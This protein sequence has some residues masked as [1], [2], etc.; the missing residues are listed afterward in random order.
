MALDPLASWLQATVFLSNIDIVR[1]AYAESYKLLPE[2]IRRGFEDI[3]EGYLGDVWRSLD[4]LLCMHVYRDLQYGP[5][6]KVELRK[7]IKLGWIA[8]NLYAAQNLLERWETLERKLWNWYNTEGFKFRTEE[9]FKMFLNFLHGYLQTTI[10]E[11]AVL[12][13]YLYHNKAIMPLGF[14]QH[15]VTLGP[16]GP[17]L[18]DFIDIDTLTFVEV[19]S[20]RPSKMNIKEYKLH[21]LS[22]AIN[23]RLPSAIA[24]PRYSVDVEREMVNSDFIV[25]EFYRLASAGGKWWIEHDEK[26]DLKAPIENELKP[27]IGNVQL[28]KK[29]AESYLNEAGR[30]EQKH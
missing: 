13:V 15:P 22:L 8:Y 10:A 18:G 17:A 3:K 16:S 14:M 12:Y 27:L 25:V 21:L 6:K 11:L 30:R 19:K 4:L 24:V 9:M 29:N 28:L 20:Q 5:K 23:T 2:D 26:R 7:R 1:E